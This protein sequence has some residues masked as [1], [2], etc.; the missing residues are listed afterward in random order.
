MGRLND[1][2]SGGSLNRG[3]AKGQR[4][5]ILFHGSP[6][7]FDNFDSEKIG[8]G[9]GAQAYGYGL[10][11]AESKNVADEYA[12]KL[13]QKTVD[14]P[15]FTPSTK[16]DQELLNAL[17]KRANSTQYGSGAAAAHHHGGH[18]AGRG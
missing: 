8:T 14:I 3:M 7:K 1:V 4:G 10:Y 15:G 18:P 11:L 16:A 13:S 9:E 2:T 6:H 17:A 12:G 5:A